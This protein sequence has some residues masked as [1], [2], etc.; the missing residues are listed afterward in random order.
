MKG[1]KNNVKDF[2]M[3]YAGILDHQNKAFL[4]KYDDVTVVETSL[5]IITVI[6]YIVPKRF[7]LLNPLNTMLED[8]L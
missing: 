3:K 5:L 8:N 6:S 7:E 2:G 4:T 1:H